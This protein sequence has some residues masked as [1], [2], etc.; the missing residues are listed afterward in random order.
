MK[1]LV[2]TQYF[3]CFS[4]Q[5]RHPFIGSICCGRSTLIFRPMR[6]MM[7]SHQM[8]TIDPFLHR[9]L[10]SE[11]QYFSSFARSQGSA[12]SQLLISSASVPPTSFDAA[13]AAAQRRHTFAFAL[14]FPRAFFFILSP[15]RRAWRRKEASGKGPTWP[16]D[17]TA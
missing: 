17:P 2:R 3:K 11:P 9:P 16:R 1:N 6:P 7:L 12:L 14:S 5:R 10:L 8:T 4:S 15:S 13:A